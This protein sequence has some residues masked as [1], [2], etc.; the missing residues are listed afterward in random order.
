M[1]RTGRFGRLPRQAPDLS[2]AIAALLREAQNQYDSNMVDAWKNGGEVE[3]K[4]VND[5][6]LLAHFRK[7]MEGLSKD[8]PLY[9][10]WEN[11]YT[12]YHF[13]IEES[14][15]ALKNDQGKISD[16]QMAAFYKSWA[17]KP[18]V[19]KN[20]EF[21]R[22]LL[23]RAAKWQAAASARS[24]GNS[25]AAAAEAHQKWVNGFYK[26][27]V[28]GSET[29]TN[30]LI[31]IAK[32]YGAAPPNA[33]SLDDIDPNSVAYGKFM[34]VI[35]DGK[36]DDPNVQGL[37]D[38][39]NH[40]IKKVSPNWEY[41]QS[42]LNDML[43]R[44]DEGLKR[45]VSESTTKTEGDQWRQRRETLRYESTRV[46]QSAANE[47]IQVAADTYALDLDSCAGDPYCAR[48]AMQKFKDKLQGE[49]KNVVAGAGS[50]TASTQDVRTSSA[51]V[52][53]IEQLDASL[54]GEEVK[55]PA[56]KVGQ[57]GDSAEGYTIFDAAGGRDTPSGWLAQ[58][59]NFINA[60]KDKLD[61][62]GWMMT[63]PMVQDGRP[64]LDG[65]GLPVYQTVIYDINTPPPAGAVAIN[66]STL[67]TDQT[68]TTLD[69]ARNGQPGTHVT[70]TPTTYILPT[71]PDVSY[72]GPSGETIP[73]DAGGGIKLFNGQ[74][75]M[76]DPWLELKGVK[77]PD[78]VTRTLY[79]TG[80]GTAQSPFLFHE[81]P[82]VGVEGTTDANGRPVIHVEQ[83]A[84]EKGNPYLKADASNIAASVAAARTPVR[85]ASADDPT[86]P[87]VLGTYS[88]S[89]ATS[90]AQAIS[91]A[92][93]TNA[94]N[95]TD[96]S[97]QY[98]RQFQQ[99]I[100]KLPMV[101][102]NGQPNPERI[103]GQR[104]YAQLTQTVSLYQ[105]GK[106]GKSLTEA[107]NSLNA[108]DPKTQNYINQLTRQGFGPN[109][110][111]GQE[112]LDRRVKLLGGLEEADKQLAGRSSLA[113][114][115]AAAWTPQ[116]G[117]GMGAGF[118]GP[119]PAGSGQQANWNKQAADLAAAKKD[120]FN[121]SIS[122]SNISIPGMPSMTPPASTTGGLS[123][124][125]GGYGGLIFG[126]P[127]AGS[128]IYPAPMST[129]APK[130]VAGPTYTPPTPPPPVKPPAATPPPP[131]KAPTP[132]PT[133]TGGA[134]T[135]TS[136][137]YATPT[138]AKPDSTGKIFYNGRKMYL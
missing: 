83:A 111:G 132:T 46:K 61:N 41:S 122:V 84:D 54:R 127:K 18:E 6:K 106:A 15:M 76:P 2:G 53:T 27:H 94:P 56:A 21:Y 81:R 86:P 68:R 67:L 133:P 100:D 25:A 51:L 49:V 42:N 17:N 36:A 20:S 98:L 97:N 12:Q 7:R 93:A 63:Q 108:N 58:T 8:D 117:L 119:N 35:E 45:L 134:Y 91:N 137:M 43:K 82:P 65:N 50:L 28:Q 33:D 11:R 125:Y 80:D 138:A 136:Y 101:G 34:D 87:W 75:P 102:A 124:G 31:A 110:Y 59:G 13:A 71:R 5:A 116:M 123:G 14:K 96:I 52:N 30:Y 105:S 9:D 85:P 62:G 19:T 39:M 129:A 79:R 37:V 70:I 131:V 66:G 22:S 74:T 1:A 90:T 4:G 73:E 57:G 114:Q 112:E 72:V 99:G 89:G 126:I 92:F 47:R 128:N 60:D 109:G 55:P 120:I 23:S 38:E 29:A 32:T 26:S 69:Q 95:A 78:G 10:E 48:N 40:E 16:G 64:V 24:A 44:G 118:A 107:Y 113:G 77:G 135:G 130:P 3:G 121:P 88:S 104:D 103:N 115:L